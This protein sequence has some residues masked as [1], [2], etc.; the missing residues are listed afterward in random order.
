MTDLTIAAGVARALMD[1]AVAKG[2]SPQALA[3]RSGIDPSDL[4]DRDNRI[5]FSK[6]VALMRAGKELCK[7]AALALHFGEAVD[8]EE[9]SIAG[10][11]GGA[12]ENL[13]DG[14]AQ[15]NRYSPLTVEVDR[16][17]TDRFVF[18]RSAGQLWMVDRRPNPNDFPELTESTFAR[19]VCT[20]RRTM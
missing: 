4:R 9:I 20:L 3:E 16:P 14:L 13:A 8:E 18:T 5:P 17:G 1:L 12:S 19:M 6:Y 2:A 15:M 7:D 11:I 10:L